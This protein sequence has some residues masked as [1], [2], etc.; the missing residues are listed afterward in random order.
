M[1]R[2]GQ[3]ALMPLLILILIGGLAGGYVAGRQV[4]QWIVSTPCG[5]SGPT[6]QEELLTVALAAPWEQAEL[7]PLRLERSGASGARL[8][9]APVPD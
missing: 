9:L 6:G 5:P 3:N 8:A 4:T 7:T 1:R 2:S